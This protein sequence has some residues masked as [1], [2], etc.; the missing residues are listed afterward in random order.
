MACTRIWPNNNLTRRTK[1]R[2]GNHWEHAGIEPNGVTSLQGHGKLL[3]GKRVELTK[4]D[5]SVEIIE[6]ENVIL[7]SRLT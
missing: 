4:P 6:A 7:A 1:Q 3:A 2:I 5:G